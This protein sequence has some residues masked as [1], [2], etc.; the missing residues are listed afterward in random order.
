LT[1]E[2][3]TIYC[4]EVGFRIQLRVSTLVARRATTPIISKVLPVAS[5]EHRLEALPQRGWRT[6][7]R[8]EPIG[9]SPG[10]TADP[11]TGA[12]SVTIASM[13]RIPRETAHAGRP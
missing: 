8:V 12:Q 4:P 2:L 1:S 9:L 10:F 6:Q 7:P 13:S 11:Q 3:G 5:K